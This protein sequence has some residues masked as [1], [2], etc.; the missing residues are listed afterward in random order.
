MASSELNSLNIIISADATPA[1]TA[2][3]GIRTKASETK[4]VLDDLSASATLSNNAFKDLVKSL[5]AFT[6]VSATDPFGLKQAAKDMAD[7]QTM[8]RSSA[9]TLSQMG[10]SLTKMSEKFRSDLNIANETANKIIGKFSVPRNLFAI[11]NK[12]QSYLDKIPGLFAQSAADRN[13]RRALIREEQ[14]HLKERVSASKSMTEDA[15]KRVGMTKKEFEETKTGAAQM[16]KVARALGKIT[17]AEGITRKAESVY[18]ES[19]GKVVD[20]IQKANTE[21]HKRYTQQQADTNANNLGVATKLSSLITAFNLN[22][23]FLRNNN[24]LLVQFG[25]DITSLERSFE[26]TLSKFIKVLTDKQYAG[27]GYGYGNPLPGQFA[28]RA[29]GKT[30]AVALDAGRVASAVENKSKQDK[31]ASE[32]NRNAVEANTLALRESIRAYTHF[33][34]TMFYADMGGRAFN[35]AY[36]KISNLQQMQA[37]ASAWGLDRNQKAMFDAQTLELKRS[38]PLMTMSDAYSMM[39][40]ASSS[41]GHYDPKLVGQTV[42]QVT[43]YAQMEKALGYNASEITDIAKN[44]Y[45]VA[46]ARQVANDIQKTLE[47]FRTVFRIT[48][49][50]AGKITVG[51]VETILRNLGPGAATITDEGLL[52]LL[53]YAEQV[54]VA[55]RGASGSAGAGIS[56]VGT[57]VKM[58][59]L[60]AM[61]KPSSIHAKKMLAELGLL[62]DGA[63]IQNGDGTYSLNYNGKDNNNEAKILQR[64]LKA[65]GG[66]NQVVGDIVLGNLKTFSSVGFYDKELAQRD[67]VKFVETLVP[68][69]EAYTSKAE[70]RA[71]YY[72]DK[73]R[74]SAEMG[75]TD[76]EFYDSLTVAEL[77]SAMTTFWAKTGLSQRVVAALATFANRNFQERSQNMMETA[78]QQKNVDQLMRE[79]IAGGN[80]TLASQRVQKSIESLVQSLEPLGVVAGKIM[81]WVADIVDAINDWANEYSLLATS[82][83]AFFVFKA[84]TSMILTLAGTYDLLNTKM[85]KRVAVENVVLA[86][87]EKR[88]RHLERQQALLAGT[89]TASAINPV[90]DVA[91]NR[92]NN[93][94]IS[95]IGTPSSAQAPSYTNANTRPAAT[96]GKTGASMLNAAGMVAL[97]QNATVKMKAAWHGLMANVF[98]SASKVFGFVAGRLIPGIGISLMALDIASIVYD[99]LSQFE[100]FAKSTEKILSG[101]K[102][103]FKDWAVTQQID[104]YFNIGGEANLGENSKKRLNE[105]KIE[106]ERLRKQA[107]DA[108][109]E[110]ND[111]RTSGFAEL[112]DGILASDNP[113]KGETPETKQQNYQYLEGRKSY[114]EKRIAELNKEEEAIKEGYITERQ[115]FGEMVKQFGEAFKNSGGFEAAVNLDKALSALAK[116]QKNLENVKQFGTEENI[117]V[118]ERYVNEAKK[119]V[120]DY[121]KELND[122]FQTD[123][124]EEIAVKLQK[125]Y[126]S[127]D[128]LA[129]KEYFADLWQKV[130][131]NMYEAAGPNIGRS[132]NDYLRADTAAMISRGNIKDPQKHT[133]A[134][135]SAFS[136][137]IMANTM[138]I[139]KANEGEGT[140]EDGNGTL[141]KTPNKKNPPKFSVLEGD[142]QKWMKEYRD[143]TR[144][145]NYD[146][147]GN[148]IKDRAYYENQA[149]EKFMQDL[150]SGKYR[151][152]NG[153]QPFLK[154]DAKTDNGVYTEN[155]FDLKLKAYGENG[156]T[157][158][159]IVSKQ[160]DSLIA[161]DFF[162]EIRSAISSQISAV[163]TLKQ[164][165][166]DL[167]NAIDSWAVPEAVRQE[168]NTVRDFNRETNER[169]SALLKGRQYKDLSNNERA[170]LNNYLA[171]RESVKNE[172]VKKSLLTGTKS[173]EQAAYQ[174]QTAGMT[175][176]MANFWSFKEE[177]RQTEANYQEALKQYEDFYQ[178]K[179]RIARGNATELAK[180]EAEY[181]QGIAKFKDAYKGYT[182]A[183]RQEYF[184]E[185][186]K[187]QTKNYRDQTKPLMTAGMTT[188]Q[189]ENWNYKLEKEQAEK[190][191]QEKLEKY[192]AYKEEVLSTMAEGSQEY[193]EAEKSISAFIQD[194]EQ[195]YQDY[196]IARDK[197]FYA[198][199]NKAEGQYI[200]EKIEQW[201][202]LDSQLTN[203]Q[204]TMMEGFVTANEKWLD[205]DLNS[206]RDYA[207]DV[208]KTLRNMAL[209][210]GYAELL[211][212]ITQGITNNVKGFFS[213][214]FGIPNGIAGQNPI[215]AGQ[216]QADN[217]GANA[218]A[219]TFGAT[220]GQ[221]IRNKLTGTPS[222]EQVLGVGSGS[223]IITNNASQYLTTAPKTFGGDVASYG[224]APEAASSVMASG[225]GQSGEKLTGIFE[226]LAVSGTEVTSGMGVLNTGMT[227]LQGTQLGYNATQLTGQIIEEAGQ[228]IGQTSN[229][230]E[231]QAAISTEGFNAAVQ[232]ATTGLIQFNT[233][234][235]ANK[236]SSAV[237]TAL[238]NGGIMTSSGPLPLKM[239]ANGGIARTAQVAIFGEGRQPEAYVPLPD[240]RSIPVTINSNGFGEQANANGNNVVISINVTNNNEGMSTESGSSEGD[241]KIASNMQKLANNIKALVK[242]EIYNQSRPGGL[243]YNG[244]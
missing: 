191:F 186:I 196:A 31:N 202:N 231:G 97:W 39:M 139:G 35:Y 10:T 93:R 168:T 90:S 18:I 217:N 131:K 82:T 78:L 233:Q 53:A 148:L 48:T 236:V 1:T 74:K 15:A 198:E 99:W 155:D 100:W 238:A 84:A 79:Q 80:L 88:I 83:A 208:L 11:D 178:E 7:V 120:Q 228:V 151:N 162:P 242:Q 239:Y 240:G 103:P 2:L 235:N 46:E 134:D 119:D 133:I 28:E 149:R 226:N 63:Y 118:A 154:P 50:T 213:A 17:D 117:A 75:Q 183:R 25:R 3:E 54:K 177:M 157:G 12:T 170:E 163:R 234:L 159:E 60:M 41:L 127:I 136:S 176:D 116:E 244:R 140:T 45:G 209:K 184:D 200:N 145:V 195:S 222:P 27:N 121:L 86:L 20:L 224:L 108:A 164:D 113:Y 223:S 8:A 203:L 193:I 13:D 14:A 185:D 70:R 126:A 44:Y 4:K 141:T 182:E 180:I 89:N 128:G 167:Q 158:E 173:Y 135:N 76:Q 37:R 47:T 9:S 229:T 150:V 68:L 225:I 30:V 23:E 102:N 107:N 19:A 207:N 156:M 189:A 175:D 205:G 147:F 59:Q 22:S 5:T 188:K 161:K 71:E 110:M 123:D 66:V 181:G 165:V 160:A 104:A 216:Q 58:L 92:N 220:A 109:I 241:S 221:W 81:L 146:A 124:V 214:A 57:N 137:V 16:A 115:Q 194:F 237:G 33:G 32:S 55:G 51:D 212:G 232:L 26:S 153:A 62:E 215:L 72:G 143:A 122:T 56:T 201:K 52:R 106:R 227:A 125:W 218:A 174:K 38:N 172:T 77:T 85:R 144:P 190:T 112:F 95:I 40:S 243:L 29:R 142:I 192:K 129:K 98:A 166:L 69:I 105:I 210:Q 67:P 21:T 169:V 65:E 138:P 42:Q 187:D 91:A 94:D 211:G 114:A 6:N 96:A 152:K 171:Q 87:E 130:M 61:G 36:D 111:I 179:K 49:T 34:A 132:F 43:K 73:G 204:D 206:W 219:S 197:A 101:I 199:R 24:A 64:F 230:Q